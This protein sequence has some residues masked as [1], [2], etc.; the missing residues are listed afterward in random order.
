MPH[1]RTD[2]HLHLDAI[3]LHVRRAAVVDAVAAVEVAVHFHIALV[4]ARAQQDALASLGVEDSAVGLLNANAFNL[5][6]DRILHE[7]ADAMLILRLR[8]AMTGS[9][10]KAVPAAAVFEGLA[11]VLVTEVT[12]SADEVRARQI[13]E[14]DEQG[15]PAQSAAAGVTDFVADRLQS[16]LN[17]L[18]VSGELVGQPVEVLFRD[19]MR[20]VHSAH[21]GTPG[22][23][24]VGV[25]ED[26]ALAGSDRLAARV[27]FVGVVVN[28]DVDVMVDFVRF[29]VRSGTGHAVAAD[30]DVVFF[31]PFNVLARHDPFA[32][33]L[34]DRL[35]LCGS[36]SRTAH[37][38][39]S[40][41][42][43]A[44]LQKAAARN[45]LC[46]LGFPPS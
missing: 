35:L 5:L 21:V 7:A 14:L 9:L 4:A 46:H 42:C 28:R 15:A 34:I 20:L 41:D 36:Q 17:P 43:E 45:I 24:I 23:Q 19:D 6:G 37:R 27:G 12:G 2:R 18:E 30:D 13:R 16:S 33:I 32:G 25:N 8:A 40:A 1:L 39:H 3:A 31:A 22:F 29:D 10:I 26:H 11:A 38:S 44:A